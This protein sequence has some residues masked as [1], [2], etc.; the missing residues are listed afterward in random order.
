MLILLPP[1]EGKTAPSSGAPLDLDSLTIPA[2]AGE[3]R[4]VLGT[5]ATV[6]ALPDAVAAL[7]VGASL[8]DEVRA[9]VDLMQAPAAP[10]HRVYTGVLFDALDYSSLSEGARTRARQHAL[11]FSA[12]F[13]ATA[14]GDRIP[15]YRL[16]ITA[17]L[18]GMGGL[19]AWWRPRITPA[20]DELSASTGVVVDCRS[21]GYAAQWKAPVETGVSV[22]VFQ[23]RAGNRTVV[24]HF[25]KHTRGLVARILLEAGGRM[26]RSPQS[27]AETVA[28]AGSGS[29]PLA[30]EGHR[31]EVDLVP[32]AGKT[33]AKLQITLPED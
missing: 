9:N 5:L 31:W 16:P 33:P 23:M 21:G 27:A 13:G 26:V 28:Q 24:S 10:G 17:K 30:D 6:S 29:G 20:L 7:G 4:T 12:L 3:R 1:S 15:A 25:A 18:P 11:V 8:E 22:D 32:A 2:L 19:A 14:L